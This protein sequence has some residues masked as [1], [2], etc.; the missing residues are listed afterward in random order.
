MAYYRMGELFAFRLGPYKAHFTTQGRYGLP[1]GR[2]DHDPPL[3]FHLGED[4]GERYDVAAERP[5]ALAAVVAA[6]DAHRAA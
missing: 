5:E 2:T 3:L 4:V 6:A 1:P